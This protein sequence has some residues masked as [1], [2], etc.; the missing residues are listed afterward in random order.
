M[1]KPVVECVRRST[2]ATGL[3][4]TEA[5]ERAYR[6]EIPVMG[7]SVANISITPRFLLG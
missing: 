5:V 7:L 1:T 6:T 2:D 3:Q 4:T